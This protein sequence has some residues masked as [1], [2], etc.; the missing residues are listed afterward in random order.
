MPTGLITELEGPGRE[1]YEAVDERVGVDPE[2]DAKN[3]PVGLLFQA[4]GGAATSW[5][6]F[7]IWDSVDAQQLLTDDRLSPALQAVGFP[8]P[9]S[10]VEWIELAAYGAAPEA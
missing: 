2:A 8:G 5:V 1:E 3:W 4:A 9:P 7:E 10:R 6:V